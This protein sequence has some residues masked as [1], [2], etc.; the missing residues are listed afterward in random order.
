MA[1]F[2]RWLRARTDPVEGRILNSFVKLALGSRLGPYEIV[3]PLGAGGM[4]EV[5]AA[6]DTRLG[7]TVALKV[8][9]AEFAD[10]PK[11]K[12]RFEREAKAISALNHPH[13]CA[14]YDVGPDYLVMEHCEGTTLATRVAGRA[15]SL[16]QVIEYGMQIADALDKAHRA[17]IV[18]RDLK[19]SNVM[20]T[21]SGV[22]L[23]DFGLAKQQGVSSQDDST[24]EAV[25][26]AGK[27][28]GT[29]QYMAPEVLQGR[30]ADARSDIFA[31]GLV[32]YEMASGKPAYTGSNRASIIAAIL[33]REPPHVGAK[34]ALDRV[35]QA[36]LARDPDQRMQSASDVRLQLQWLVER[37]PARWP[38]LALIA[39]IVIVA[40][41]AAAIWRFWPR[42]PAPT[43][44]RLEVV[45]ITSLNGYEVEP[46]LSS[47]GKRVAFVWKHDNASHIFVKFIGRAE[48][49]QLTRGDGAESHPAWSPDGASIAFCRATPQGHDVVAVDALGGPERVLAHSTAPPLG[50]DYA[51]DGKSIAMADR[52]AL[53]EEPSLFLLST[54]SGEKRRLTTPNDPADPRAASNLCYDSEPSFSPDG[55]TVAFIHYLLGPGFGCVYRQRV[56]DRHATVVALGSF[57]AHQVKWSRD[58]KMLI[59]AY[60]TVGPA[61]AGLLALP[62]DYRSSFPEPDEP[63]AYRLPFGGGSRSLA[64][65]GDRIV[66]SAASDDP[67]VWQFP[68]PAATEETAPV[69]LIAST[70]DDMA[71]SYSPDG[72]HIAFSSDRDSKSWELWVADANGGN[73]RRLTDVGAWGLTAEWSPD[74]DRIAFRGQPPNKIIGVYVI[75]ASGGIARRL[76]DEKHRSGNGGW[77]P[78]GRSLYFSSSDLTGAPGQIYRFDF[79][80]NRVTQIGQLPFGCSSPHV[81]RD[82]ILCGDRGTEWSMNLSG[83]DL[84]RVIAHY[85]GWRTLWRDNLLYLTDSGTPGLALEMLD[86][87][88]GRTRR[89]RTFAPDELYDGG[90]LLIAVS[91]DGKWILLS[92]VDH[93]GADLMEV[94]GWQ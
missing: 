59:V 4:G 48:L 8:L 44:P 68:G 3:A 74:G 91:P 82:R 23:L 36:C 9:P 30:E 63:D 66:F 24:L 33:E 31:L 80:T 40:I 26:E 84:H 1:M 71:W 52:A 13:I 67:N 5:Y 78:D 7:R 94:D 93:A 10:D 45:P 83:G 12:I 32:L 38:P 90:K 75:D 54:E 15:L 14:L 50:I 79:D 21:P 76:T 11:F 73:Q 88:T 60:E 6:R 46:A 19:P 61:S 53:G 64:V 55:R 47:D 20:I 49:Q 27:I 72:K 42:R 18:H 77:S 41:A 35:I 56:G 81:W 51:P 69:K 92:R 25:T 22:K 28:A 62:A 86:L 70:R 65:A 85:R 39:A 89:L 43:R 29:P 2:A 16:A 58:G 37:R 17:G 87:V 57:T 34:P